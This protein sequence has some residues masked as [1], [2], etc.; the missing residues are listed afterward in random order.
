MIKK[1]MALAGGMGCAIALQGCAVGADGMEESIATAETNLDSSIAITGSW[2]GG[3]CAKVTVANNMSVAANK[4]TVYLDMKGS[5]I[6][7]VSTGRNVWDAVAHND[8]GTVKVTQKSGAQAIPASGTTT[9]GFCANAPSSTARAA[10]AGF[11]TTLLQYAV[12]ST[13]NGLHP[14]RASLAVAM[15]TELGRWKPESDLTI[16]GDGKVALTAGGLAACTN[17]C[18]NT[19]AI[20]GQQD[21]AVSSYSGPETFNSTVFREDMKASFNRVQ[22]KLDDL[23]RNNPGALPPAHKLALVGA[24]TNLGGCGPHYVYKATD[25]NGVPLTSTQASNLANALC[26][27]GQGTCGYNP[28]IGFVTTSQG[29]PS[30]QTCVAIDPDDGDNGTTTTSTAGTAPKYP[31]NRLW[32][33]TNSKLNTA[34][35]HTQGYLAKMKSKCSI[36][37]STCGYLYCML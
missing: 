22:T 4:W 5:S 7:Y 11:N 35:E 8:S 24:P 27:Y 14:T 26:F 2:N 1:L 20:L 37:S 36:S 33:P 25:L 30:G 3:Y 6:Q 13:N 34:C 16:G 10:I 23:R 17:G 9:F 28:Y 12:C 18:P 15:A 19:K 31:L 32:D 21:D 29:C